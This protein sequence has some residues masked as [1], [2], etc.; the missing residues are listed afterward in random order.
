VHYIL[1]LSIYFFHTNK[2]PAYSCR[3]LPFSYHCG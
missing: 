3:M 2:D 1:C